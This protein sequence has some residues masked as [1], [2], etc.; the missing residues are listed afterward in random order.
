VPG[1]A[2]DDDD[3]DNAEGGEETLRQSYEEI[4]GGLMSVAPTEFLQCLPQCVERMRR[5]ISTPENKTLALYLGCDLIANLKEKSEPAWPVFMPEVFQVI[6]GKDA[7][8]RTAAAYAINLAAPLASFA[9]AAPQAFRRLAEVVSHAKPGR[10]K[11]DEKSRMALDNAVA[12]LLTLAKEQPSHCPPDV[13]AWSIII[14]RLPLKA[15]EEEARKVHEKIIDLV[16]EEHSGLLGGP[17][18]QNLGQV[19]SVLAEVYK[20]EAL[21]KKEHEEK[22]LRVFR[23][24]PVDMLKGLA[25]GFTEKQQKKIEKMLTS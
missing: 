2:D 5:W 10:L 7:D 20:I 18:R 3:E 21:C 4:I 22:I 15:D 19:L 23:S 14:S 17:S 9:E 25:A 8:A 16:L 24:L 6:G 13:Q 12:A 1:L 11:R